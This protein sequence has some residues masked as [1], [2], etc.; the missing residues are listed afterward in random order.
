MFVDI[1]S[2]NMHLYSKKGKYVLTFKAYFATFNLFRKENQAF[3]FK[4]LLL[5]LF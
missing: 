5:R 2:E 4:K 3:M 1:F